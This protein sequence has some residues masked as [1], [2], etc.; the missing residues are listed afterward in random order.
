MHFAGGPIR[1][2]DPAAPGV[3]QLAVRGPWVVDDDKAGAG[4]VELGERCVL[5]GFTD[6]HV[7]FPTWS[8]AQRVVRLEGAATLEEALAR[9]REAE[10][11]LPDG[12]WLFGQGWRSGDWQ[13]SLEPRLAE[14]E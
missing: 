7:H 11:A 4:V 13:P 5:P 9:V 6:S 3:G 1:T 10:A 8:L 12:R 2:L 14:P